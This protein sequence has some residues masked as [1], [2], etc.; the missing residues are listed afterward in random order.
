M[1]IF[2]AK[3]FSKEILEILYKNNYE[4]KIGFFDNIDSKNLGMIYN[5]YPI[6]KNQTDLEDF[7]ST[8]GNNFTLGI[9]IP[10]NRFKAFEFMSRYGGVLTSTISKNSEIGSF[11]TYVDIGCN[12]TSGVIITNDVNI[13]RG[14]LINLNVT[15]GHNSQIGEFSELCPGVNISGNCNIGDFVFIGTNSTILPNISIGKNS[16]IGAGSVVTKDIPENVLAFGVPAE[17]VKNI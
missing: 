7:F 15:I 10:A 5:E 2:G 1:I 17:I 4:N 12:I 3:G 16:I 14:S 11:N 13:G 9:G 6:L 8:N